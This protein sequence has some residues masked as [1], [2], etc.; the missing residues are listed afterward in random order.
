MG[1]D[2]LQKRARNRTSFHRF[3]GAISRAPATTQGSRN[4]VLSTSIHTNDSC[5]ASIG[6]PDLVV[7]ER[8]I[9]RNWLRGAS[10]N[11]RAEHQSSPGSDRQ[12]ATHVSH[13]Y[14]CAVDGSYG[15]ACSHPW[16]QASGRP[17]DHAGYFGPVREPRRAAA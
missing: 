11:G 3:C 2:G 15:E 9:V 17:R 6:H 5:R 4:Q 1:H 14:P 10:C 12:R 13:S 7:S 8:A 16:R